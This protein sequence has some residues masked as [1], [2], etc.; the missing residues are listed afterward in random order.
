MPFKKNI[1]SSWLQN[2]QKE[3]PEPL[4]RKF[5]CEVQFMYNCYQPYD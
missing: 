2:R 4:L 3:A 5:S 1:K